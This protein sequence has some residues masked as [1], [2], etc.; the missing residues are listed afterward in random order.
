MNRVPSNEF[1]DLIYPVCSIRDKLSRFYPI[2]VEETEKA[3]IRN[4]AMVVN[5]F[6]SSSVISFS[7]SDY[8]LYLVGYWNSDKGLLEPVSPLKLLA[9]GSDLVGVKYE[10]S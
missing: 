6:K 4:F 1:P 8:E 2:S 9:N 3:A 5:A 7:P 10:E